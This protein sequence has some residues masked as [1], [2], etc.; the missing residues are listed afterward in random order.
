MTRPEGDDVAEEFSADWLALR[1]AVDHESRSALVLAQARAWR[2]T[3]STPLSVMDLGTGTGSNYRYLQ[4]HWDA[5]CHWRLVDYNAALLAALRDRAPRDAP[6]QL[7]HHDLNALESLDFAGI[8]LVTAS[9]LLDLTTAAWIDR[10][11]A[12]CRRAGNAVWIALS[13]NGVQEWTP[14][15]AGDE[16]VRQ[17]FNAHQQRDKGFGA[18]LG[19]AGGEYL[20]VALANAGYSVTQTPADWQLIGAAHGPLL[21]RLIDDYAAVAREMGVVE[22]DAWRQQRHACLAS[23]HLRVGHDDVLGLLP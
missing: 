16:A 5:N 10:L 2:Q 23:T 9:A 22:V 7:I 15:V 18:A 6:M 19:P 4:A 3:Q 13:V 21:A 1:E 14:T 12:Q 11:V 17:G 8:S 20:G